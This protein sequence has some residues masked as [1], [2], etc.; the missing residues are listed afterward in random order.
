VVRDVGIEEQARLIP[1][2][3]IALPG[4]L[5]APLARWTVYECCRNDRLRN[6]RILQLS[7]SGSS[8]GKGGTIKQKLDGGRWEPEVVL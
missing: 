6:N 5:S 8:D 7:F 2:P 3:Q 1:I 4:L